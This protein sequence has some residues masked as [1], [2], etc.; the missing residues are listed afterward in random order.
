M[1]KW[2]A[3]VVLLLGLGHPVKTSAQSINFDNSTTR[4]VVVGIS[5]YF[6]GK[7]PDLRFADKDAEA[8]AAY[9]QSPAGGSLGNEQ[10]ILLTNAKATTAQFSAGLDWLIEQSKSGDEAIIYFSGHGDVETSTIMNWGF[11][12]TYSTPPTNY[13]AGAFPIYYLQSVIATLSQKNVKVVMISDACHA[14]KLAGSEFG[15]TQATALNLSKQFANEVKIM[16]CQPEEQ[17]GGGR[18]AFSFN[19]IEG[20]TGLADKNN[21]GTV[22]LL[23]IENYLEEVVPRETAPQSQIPMTIGSK[24]STIALVDAASLTTL[25]LQKSTEMLSLAKVETKGYEE[26]VLVKVDTIVQELYAAFLAAIEHGELLAPSGRSANDLYER[27]VLEESLKPLHGFMKRNLAAAL[28]DKAQAAI[29][30]YLSTDKLELEK[31]S[32][33]DSSYFQYPKYL[34]RA[35]DLLGEGH[36]MYRNL[37]AKQYYFEGLVI[38]LQRDFISTDK[39]VPWDTTMTA[40]ALELQYKALEYES[41]AA[42]IYHELGNLNRGNGNVQ[43]ALEYSQKSAELSPKWG[44]TLNYY[45]ND[46][47]WGAGKIEEGISMYKR[48]LMVAPHYT[49]LYASIVN[50]YL[51]MHRYDEAEDWFDKAIK[52][53]LSYHSLLSIFYHYQKLGW[54]EKCEIVARKM[55]SSTHYSK[56]QRQNSYSYLGEALLLLKKNEEALAIF[57]ALDQGKDSLDLSTAYFHA[58]I[59]LTKINLGHGS[60][61]LI[62]LKAV[63]DKYPEATSLSTILGQGF[64]KLKRYD[65]AAMH[66]NKVL[67]IGESSGYLSKNSQLYELVWTCAFENETSLALQWLE[68]ILK[69]GYDDFERLQFDRVLE[70]VRMTQQFKDLMLKYFPEQAKD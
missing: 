27:L 42:F 34:S 44:L 8:F 52:F 63:C 17:W 6:D 36:Y 59:G 41:R 16:S 43:K 62:E 37:K 30:L 38:R 65:E 48:A 58:Y 69:V 35:A 12:L 24:A 14:G 32:R 64:L 15:G 39:G 68:T 53:D 57:L 60:E 54:F 45:G 26:K 7:I 46:L 11:L 50:G 56:S 55:V 40:K 5:D 67:E 47:I 1:K 33:L 3:P 13:I 66:F 51:K 10:I 9:L 4:A 25:K 23:E 70:D 49:D 19:L 20:L 2:L 28:H 61:G 21:D 18:G 29:N 31:R 22:K